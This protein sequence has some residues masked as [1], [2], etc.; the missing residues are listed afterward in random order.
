MPILTWCR[1][2]TYCTTTRLTGR[3]SYILGRSVKRSFFE[4]SKGEIQLVKTFTAFYATQNSVQFSPVIPVLSYKSSPR[5]AILPLGSILITSCHS[6]L[7]ISPFSFSKE[8]NGK[9]LNI[10]YSVIQRYGIVQRLLINTTLGHCTSIS[11]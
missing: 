5:S 9:T 7:G 4:I 3:R 6:Q 11:R 8:H 10:G 1:H 2:V